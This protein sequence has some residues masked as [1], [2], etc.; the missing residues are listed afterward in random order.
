MLKGH[1]SETKPLIKLIPSFIPEAKSN[2]IPFPFNQ[3]DIQ[4]FLVDERIPG[5]ERPTI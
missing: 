3:T 5:Y 2:N 4:S 1:D